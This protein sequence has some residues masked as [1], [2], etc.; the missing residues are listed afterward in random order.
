[1]ALRG[2]LDL[3]TVPSLEDHLWSLEGEG[4]KA[5][6]LDLRD[7]TFIDST[8]LRALLVAWDHAANN[9]HRLA[10]VGASDDARKLLAVTGTERMLEEPEGVELLEWFTR[11]R[12]A[13]RSDLR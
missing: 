5:I 4:V 13:E 12:P 11:G 6:I 8:G 7:L 2:E 10:I 9:G 1:V 3:A